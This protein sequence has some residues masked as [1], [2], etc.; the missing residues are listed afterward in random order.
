MAA[1]GITSVGRPRS[2]LDSGDPAFH[3][4]GIDDVDQVEAAAAAQLLDGLQQG[5]RAALVAAAAE[6]HVGTAACQF[7][8]AVRAMSPSPPL[9]M[10]T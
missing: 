5:R 2:S 6:G 8:G 4:V 9:M 7:E 10:A 3:G 1:L